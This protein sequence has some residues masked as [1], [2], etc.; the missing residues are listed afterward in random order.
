MS[1]K[2]GLALGSGS[3]RGF[4]HLGILEVFEQ[5][6]IKPDII[7]GSSMGSV[8]GGIYSC[9]TDLE[10]IIKLIPML[11][12]KDYF[13]I[14]SPRKGGFLKGERFQQLINMFTKNYTFEKTEIEF[15]CVS[16]DLMCGE[17]VVHDKGNIADGIRASMS[18]PGVFTP[19]ELNGRILVD[20]GVMCRV[21]ASIARD[22]G[23]DVVIGVDVGYRGGYTCDDF[24]GMIDTITAATDIMGWQIQKHMDKD[25]D[26]M[27]L[28]PVR[29]VNPNTF[30]DFEYAVEMGR[31][32]A[33]DNIEQILEL[34]E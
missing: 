31:K 32:V 19:H 24:H 18:I 21:P 17:L 34:I 16:V 13:D 11:N 1:K 25:A 20:G 30:K 6:K 5:Y 12:E 28:P 7:V 8:I 3:A 26:I 4:A 10:K 2:I 14:I 22:K 23:A 27:L 29:V 33:N 15:A 9:G